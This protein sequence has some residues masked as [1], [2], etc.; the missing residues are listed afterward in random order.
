M[1]KALAFTQ[2]VKTGE[3]DP[4]DIKRKQVQKLTEPD[5]Q[6]AGEKPDQ[7]QTVARPVGQQPGQPEAKSGWQLQVSLQLAGG[8]RT[9]QQTLQP[10]QA[11]REKKSQ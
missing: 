5:E 11:G 7:Q 3:F 10:Q 2:R 4:P 8:E 9:D 6:M 1:K